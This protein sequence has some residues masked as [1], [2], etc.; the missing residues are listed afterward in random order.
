MKK[1]YYC[2]FCKKYKLTKPAIE[3]HEKHCT[4]NPNRIC[5][6]CRRTKPVK[7]IKV[8]L[9]KSEKSEF[10]GKSY[11]GEEVDKYKEKVDK[12]LQNI[13][14][15]MCKFSILRQSKILDSTT[16]YSFD[17]NNELKKYWEEAEWEA[18]QQ[19][20]HQKIIKII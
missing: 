11:S 16:F 9:P 3:I 1:I 7:P 20:P 2:D 15:P 19:P 6:V 5:R 13:D 17:L 18:S 14:C 4:L 10:G 12:L 8:D